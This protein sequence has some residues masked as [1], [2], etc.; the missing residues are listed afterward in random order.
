MNGIIELINC[1]KCAN[2][3]ARLAHP[4]CGFDDREI[5]KVSISYFDWKP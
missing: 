2:R 5:P 3:N 1:L 4:I